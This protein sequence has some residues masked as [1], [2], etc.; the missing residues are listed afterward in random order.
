MPNEISVL[1]LR[2]SIAAVQW[3]PV[4]QAPHDDEM[5]NVGQERQRSHGV[6]QIVQQHTRLHAALYCHR[7]LILIQHDGEALCGAS[8][9]EPP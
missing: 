8:L 3:R 6:C 9:G 1:T 7:L 5:S 2:T 4:M